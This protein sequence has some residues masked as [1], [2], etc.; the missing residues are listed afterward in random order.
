M[1]NSPE[2]RRDP[3]TGRWVI[4]APERSQRPMALDGAEPGRRANFET[5]P[6]PFCSGRESATPNEVFAIREA[7][8]RPDA[9]GW[10][11]RVVPN[12]FPAVR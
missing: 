11:L 4:V 8:S 7:G 10:R 6:C 5:G 3:V 1:M 2:F 9:S 12:M